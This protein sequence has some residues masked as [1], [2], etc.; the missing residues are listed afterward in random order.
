MRRYSRKVKHKGRYN[1]PLFHEHKKGVDEYYELPKKWHEV[2]IEKVKQWI[3]RIK[4]RW[5]ELD[6]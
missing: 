6:L 1:P 2:I 3:E 4:E 5:E